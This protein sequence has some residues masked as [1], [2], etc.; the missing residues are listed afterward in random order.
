VQAEA[1]VADRAGSSSMNL[2]N[3]DQ[4]TV[5]PRKIADYLL[6]E[7]HPDNGGKARFFER[8]GYGL[9]E[10]DSLVEAL[11]DLASFDRC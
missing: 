6:N 9:H 5:D 7:N 11:R 8:L 2:P 10:I 1:L 4:A 3:A